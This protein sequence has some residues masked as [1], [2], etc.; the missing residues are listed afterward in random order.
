MAEEKKTTRKTAP[1]KTT[2]KKTSK[3]SEVV[4]I[5][6]PVE[7]IVSEEI[8]TSEEKVTSAENVTSA[9]KGIFVRIAVVLPEEGLKI[10]TGPGVNY[11]KCGKLD[12]GTEVEVLEEKDGFIRIGQDQWVMKSYLG[13]I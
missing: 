2:S 12:A 3:K 7:P 11:P 1:K 13:G 10:R 6:E 4:E 5:K 8:V 9:E